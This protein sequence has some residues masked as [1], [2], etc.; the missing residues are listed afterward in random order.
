MESNGVAQGSVAAD[1]RDAEDR[2]AAAEL[3]Y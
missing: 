1:L 2:I 3:T